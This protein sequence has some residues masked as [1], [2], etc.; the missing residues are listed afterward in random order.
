MKRIIENKHQNYKKN[1]K[2]FKLKGK[3]LNYVVEMKIKNIEIHDS[4]IPLTSSMKSFEIGKL[5]E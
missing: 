2:K 5:L 1:H 3:K 4:V